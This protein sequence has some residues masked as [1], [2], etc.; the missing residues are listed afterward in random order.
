MCSPLPLLIHSGTLLQR[1]SPPSLIVNP[2]LATKPVSPVYTHAI[3]IPINFSLTS[4]FPPS[5]CPISL[6]SFTACKTVT[7][8]CFQFHS[9]CS[10]MNPFQL[11]SHVYPTTKASLIK[12]IG[13]LHIAKSNSQ[14]S[15]LPYYLLYRQQLT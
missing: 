1:F 10:I 11:D 8:L 13:D 14:F 15:V 7:S 4:H 9:S 12:V 5:Y 6:L 3:L 2:H